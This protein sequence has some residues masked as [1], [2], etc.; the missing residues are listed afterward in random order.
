MAD[1]RLA[2]LPA[3]HAL[4]DEAGAL[5][6][7]PRWALIEAARRAIAT[8]REAI[9]AGGD[10]PVT[11]ASVAI[12]AVE[13]ARPSLRRVINATGVVLHTNL[14]RAP[15]ADAARAAIDEVAARLREPRVRPRRAASAAR[16]TIT[17]A[18]CCA[19]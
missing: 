19:S 16:A 1:P 12:L 4:A 11:A 2:K 13:L 9:L 18:S 5:A 15:L 3:V 10:A 6:T 7:A 8:A 17:C 14:G